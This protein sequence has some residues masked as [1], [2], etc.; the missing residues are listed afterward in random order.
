M[1]VSQEI[2][3]MVEERIPAGAAGRVTR[4]GVVVGDDAGLEAGS[5]QFCLETLLGLP[6]FGAAAPAIRREPGDALRLE[7]IDVEDPPPA[8]AATMTGGHHAGAYH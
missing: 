7:F 4:V 5:L 1:S 2:C 3:R 8:G 6:P